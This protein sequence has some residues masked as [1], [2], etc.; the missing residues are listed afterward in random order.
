MAMPRPRPRVGEH[1][2]VGALIIVAAEVLSAGDDEDLLRGES[3][4]AP[5]D[6]K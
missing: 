6:V 5:N 3:L 4:G 1:D 2:V